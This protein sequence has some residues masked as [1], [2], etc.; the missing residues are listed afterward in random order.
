MPEWR[1]IDHISIAVRD[2]EAGEAFYTPLLAAIGHTKMREWPGSAI[3]YGKKH[4]EF[5]INL[6]RDMVSVPAD[7][8][9]HICLRA[10]SKEAVNAFYAAAIAN[11]GS[12]DGEPGFRKK[13]DARYYA[14]F[15][16][17]PDGNRIEAVTFVDP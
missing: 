14:A 7:S 10:S 2:I 1:V 16:R 12:S 4:P 6:R 15:I 5:W 3:G 13:Y 9:V 17:D 11:G 8:G